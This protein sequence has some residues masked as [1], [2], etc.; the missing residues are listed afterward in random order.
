MST[1]AA[2]LVHPQLTQAWGTASQGPSDTRVAP[3]PR[4]PAGLPAFLSAWEGK[5]LANSLLQKLRLITSLNKQ[6]AARVSAAWG[7]GNVQSQTSK[8]PKR[9]SNSNLSGFLPTAF[10]AR[11]LIAQGESWC[12]FQTE[13]FSRLKSS[14]WY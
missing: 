11:A 10:W 1:G 2:G 4:P 5:P 3:Q 6:K 8:C 13:P 7:C 12:P 9:S 14:S